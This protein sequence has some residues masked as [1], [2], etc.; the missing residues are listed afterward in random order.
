MQGSSENL[1]DISR[2]LRVLVLEG[3]EQGSGYRKNGGEGRKEGRKLR[4][5]REAILALIK[6]LVCTRRGER[7]CLSREREC[8]L[9]STLVVHTGRTSC[10][11]VEDPRRDI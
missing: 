6:G 1:Q 11:G 5:D 9:L 8:E 7:L 3:R 4:P 2:G 10:W